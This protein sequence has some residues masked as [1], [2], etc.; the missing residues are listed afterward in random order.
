MNKSPKGDFVVYNGYMKDFSYTKEEIRLFRKLNTPQKIQDYLCKVPFNFD[1]RE[2]S[3]L[4]PRMVLKKNKA[5]CVEG[6]IFAATV[7]EFHGHKPLLLDLRSVK[8]PYDYDHVVALF[9]IDGCY[10]SISKTNHSVLRY[11][12][13]VYKSIRELVMSYFHEYFL[14]NGLKSLREYS[15][16]FN[17]NYFN[18]L[19]W[20]TSDKNLSEILVHLDKIK[21][22]KI[23]TPKQIKNLRKADRIEIK[24]SWEEEYNNRA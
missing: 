17:L 13:P 16:P 12:E 19:A 15:D 14:T 3:C 7:L 6:A 23:L 22:Y 24:G 10:G 11:R 21:H 1:E 5:D 9:K 4:S 2:G 8:K 18:K 20:R